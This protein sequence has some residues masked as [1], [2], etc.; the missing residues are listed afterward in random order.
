MR[1]LGLNELRKEFLDFFEERGHN[2]LESFPLVPVNDDSLLLINA[3]MAPLKDY[4]TGIKK[5]PGNRATSSQKC[6][7]TADIDRVGKTARHGT[8]FEM[9][10]NFSFGDYFKE[11]TIK[12]AWE[13]MT[14]KME[15]DPEIL[16]VSIY[17]NDDEAFK[18][19]NE[20]I[21]VPAEKII[22]LGKADN[23]WELEVGPCGPCSEIYV[24]RGLDYGCGDENCKP[25]C[26]CDRFMEVWNLVFTQ[27]DKDKNGEY[28]PLEHPNIDTGMGLERLALISEGVDNIFEVEIIRN[29]INGIE[30][31]SGKKYKSSAEVDES[32]RVISDHV[33]A[34]VFLVS[35]GVVPS[36][37]GRGY[38]LRRLIRRAVRHGRLLGISDEFLNEI[39]QLVIDS[40]KD[41]YPALSQNKDM[42][43]KVISAEE[44]KFRE[45]ILQGLERLNDLI[46]LYEKESLKML[47]G[48]EVFKLYDTY[49]FPPDL[50]K[51][52]AS[53]RDL[54]IDE[55]G[56]NEMMMKQ[57]IRSR[58][59]RTDDGGFHA[60]EN[61]VYTE[62]SNTEFTGYCNTMEQARVLE[63]YKDGEL[64]D[65]LEEGSRGAVI[66]DKTCFYG[67][68][69][70][71][72]GDIGTISTKEAEADVI[73]T[74]KN[75]NLAIIHY[76]EVKK[77]SIRVGD[78]AGL[79]VDEKTRKAIMKNHSATHLLH[80]ALRKVLGEHVN[81]AGS[82]VDSK[83]L[84]FDFSHYEAISKK[85][86]A[87]IE[88]LVNEMI[89]RNL[90]VTFNEMSLGDAN[91]MG[92]I[93]LFEDKYKDVVRVVAMGDESIELCGGT[94]VSDTAEIQML[95]IV[96]ESGIAAGVRR[97]EAI[98]G[99]AVYEYLNSLQDKIDTVCSNLKTN[100]NNLVQ[101]SH[102]IV[103]E[104]KNK[105]K[106]IE[107]I[108]LSVGSSS[109]DDILAKVE[110]VGDVKYLTYLFNDMDMDTL[111][112]MGDQLRDKI[113]SAVVVLASKN[114]GKVT[115]LTTVSKDLLKLGLNAG[116]IVKETAKITGGNG[117]GRPDFAT[118]GGKDLSKID[119]ALNNV[120][121]LIKMG[122][123]N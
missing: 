43:F 77:G 44:D 107:R 65:S 20:E 12:W 31:L 39:G 54:D 42:I 40:Y 29:I 34:I 66:F 57:K 114:D 104:L 59:S 110:Q 5:M 108:K 24:D 97:I 35:D 102:S 91:Q 95:K 103:E 70:G 121:K 50:T 85:D 13:F 98:T 88:R 73:D 105:D 115:F 82:L 89:E 48:K 96:S 119:E 75:S 109:I 83:K 55:E 87:E 21:K 38:V 106:E 122:I 120:T 84:R 81:Q 22:R 78:D 72:V 41:S 25:G 11:E 45:T 30:K 9:L 69:G 56:F 1:K 32:I 8:F 51:E 18:I 63:L 111:R 26:D 60:D 62:I 68:G 117:G 94:H 19:W 52:I 64:V 49:G 90:K 100:S 74:K 123:D 36:N 2:R 7:R 86:L 61:P 71:Q 116:K 76:V 14:E 3:G 53:E 28:H 46:E 10:G 113:G 112:K 101:R 67:E 27:F 58:E 17:E 47:D 15:I 93:G 118:A 6:I 80:R 37:E 4:F 99:H 16:W 92:A 33:R 79:I 23:F